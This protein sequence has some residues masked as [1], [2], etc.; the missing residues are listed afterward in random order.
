VE[1]IARLNREF[2]RASVLERPGGIKA[3]A[4]I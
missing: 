1:N 2:V 3:E 4:S